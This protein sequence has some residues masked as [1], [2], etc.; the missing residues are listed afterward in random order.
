MFLKTSVMKKNILTLLILTTMNLYINGQKQIENDSFET[1]SGKFSIYFLGHASL[2]FEFNGKHIFID[3]VSQY[4]DYSKLPKASVILITHQHPDHFDT[5]AISKITQKSTQIIVTPAVFDAYKSGIIFNNGDKK[6]IEE[7]E[8]E[9]VPAYNNTIGREK[10]HPK[11][12]DNGYIITLG[13]MR[14]YIAGDTENIP[15]MSSFKNIDIAF[16]PM[17]QPFTMLPEQV[18]EATKRINP[19]IL[20]PYHYGDTEVSKIKKILASDTN[21]EVR[22]RSLK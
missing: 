18:A 1:P 5:R 10:Y 14:I 2:M 12:R 20:Y 22:I 17:N 16:L 7:I 21:T 19:K 15:E 13:N 8:I 11:G 3:P 9:A 6:I 4:A